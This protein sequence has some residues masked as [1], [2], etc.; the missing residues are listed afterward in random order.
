MLFDIGKKE[1]ASLPILLI[2][3]GVRKNV[4]TNE[5]KKEKILDT[6]LMYNCFFSNMKLKTLIMLNYLPIVYTT[7]EVGINQQI[8]HLVKVFFAYEKPSLRLLIF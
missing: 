1:Y 7:I 3:N 6:K 2:I 4:I 5:T 8:Y